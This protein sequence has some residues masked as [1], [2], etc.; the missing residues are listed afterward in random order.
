VKIEPDIPDIVRQTLLIYLRQFLKSKMT[1]TADSKIPQYV[2]PNA[3]IE[4]IEYAKS[5]DAKDTYGA[6]A[7]RILTG[8]GERKNKEGNTTYIN[9]EI[10]ALINGKRQWVPIKIQFMNLTTGA[11]IPKPEDRKKTEAGGG[12]KIQLQFRDA[13]SFKLRTPDGERTEEFGK[14]MLMLHYA[15]RFAVKKALKERKI[16][17]L[18]T[19]RYNVVQTHRDTKAKGDKPATPPD[20]SIP[21]IVIEEDPEDDSHHAV[22]IPGMPMPMKAPLAEGERIIRATLD[23]PMPPGAKSAL[24]NATPKIKVYDASIRLAKPDADGMI[25]PLA[26]EENIRYDRIHDWLKRGSIASG[27]ISANVTTL[28]SQGISLP[29][30]LDTLI[31]KPGKGFSGPDTG[32]AFGSLMDQIS[33]AEVT[34]P[35]ATTMGADEA[36]EIYGDE[37]EGTAK[38]ATKTAAAAAAPAKKPTAK[39]AANPPKAAAKPKIPEPEPEDEE[40]A[41]EE[42]VDE[43]A[44]DDDDA[45]TTPLVKAKPVAKAA[46]KAPAKVATKAPIKPKPKVVEP[47]PELEETDE[48]DEGGEDGDEGDDIDEPPVVVKPKLAPSRAAARSK[49]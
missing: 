47:E 29:V 3:I 20:P 25:S 18:K 40:D 6:G 37:D 1:S 31:V 7:I 23:Y 32:M 44:D 4:A 15:W 19:Q 5:K 33:T 24:P 21:N 17:H 35:E 48:V 26:K 39:A 12:G 34:D 30:K 46:A 27:I 22:L 42:A 8:A 11:N 36:N 16:Q 2:W 49:Q 28:S 43:V 45:S 10:S 14:A 9:T 41:I 38:P 13:D